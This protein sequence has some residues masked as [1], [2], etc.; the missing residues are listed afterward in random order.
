MTKSALITGASSGLG[1]EFA[2]QL[3]ARG[4]DL[5]LVA[6]R[7]ERLEQ[8]A[9]SL[10]TKH[11]R[12]ITVLPVDLSSMQ[13]INQVISF[14]ASTTSLE[15]LV[16]N[17]GFGLMR[18]FIKVDAERE[19]AL[20][21]VHI[22]APVMLSRASLPAMVSRNMGGIINVSSMAGIIPIR[23]VLYGTSKSFLIQ[24]SEALHEE[25]RNNNIRIQALC[26]GFVTTEF[27][28]TPDFSRFQ[29]N[30]IP[31]F[32]WLSP[33]RVV[34]DSLKAMERHRVVCVPGGFYGFIA[35]L[36]RIGVTSGMVKHAARY[37]IRRR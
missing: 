15:L 37:V 2:Q 31:G 22:L 28:D 33:E 26:P 4:Y 11:E 35:A 3:A 7:E 27:H 24:F 16:N 17:A 9:L 1:V 14:I 34:T 19:L 25:V 10:Q 6:R 36:A 18:R 20:L 29:R 23:S 30:R 5:I 21:H 32:L 13:G 12:T 8:L